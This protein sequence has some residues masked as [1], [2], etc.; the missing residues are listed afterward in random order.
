MLV[1]YIILVHQPLPTQLYSFEYLLFAS[2]AG[3]IYSHCIS[4]I[5]VIILSINRIQFHFHLPWAIQPRISSP[6]K[7][8]CITTRH[9]LMYTL[10]PYTAL[11]HDNSFLHLLFQWHKQTSGPLDPSARHKCFGITYHNKLKNLSNSPSRQSRIKLHYPQSWYT[12]DQS[13][14]RLTATYEHLTRD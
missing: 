8:G 1:R 10:P 9:S 7:I 13:V 5:D 3:T 2:L 11:S 6:P 12:S 4:H 14:D